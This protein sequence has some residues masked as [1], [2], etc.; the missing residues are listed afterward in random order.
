MD[1]M[2]SWDRKAWHGRLWQGTA[3]TWW[4]G[5]ALSW[6]GPPLPCHPG[7]ACMPRN[8]SLRYSPPEK[9]VQR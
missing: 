4:H 1:N 3:T 7:I 9:L 6:P 8:D 2:I 5:M